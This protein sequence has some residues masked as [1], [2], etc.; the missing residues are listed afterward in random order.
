MLRKFQIIFLV[1]IGFTFLFSASEIK[2]GVL[3]P[4]TGRFD[5]AGQLMK[6]GI[7]TANHLKDSVL[8]RK[9]K[10]VFADT[11]STPEGT[12][13]AVE[14]LL[15]QGV[16]AII[17][18][19]ASSNTLVAAE[20]C[21]KNKITLVVP[22]ATN[23]TITEGKIYVSRI[24]FTDDLQGKALA[25]FVFRNLRSEK[26]VVFTD[27]T[28]LYS[29]GLSKYFIEQ[30]KKYSSTFLEINYDPIKTDFEKV[31]LKTLEYKPRT[32][33][34]TGYSKEIAIVYRLLKK[35]D[36]KGYIVSGDA[37]YPGQIRDINGEPAEGLIYTAIYHPEAKFT[38]T[39][40]TMLQTY[41]KLF[42]KEV[43][44]FAA[45]STSFDAYMILLDSIERAKSL[46]SI[47]IAKALRNVK[48]FQGATGV[49]TID[50]KTG[51]ALT[52]ILL[53]QI[54]KGEP[55]YLDRISLEM[56]K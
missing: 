37:T 2:I 52:S 31:V 49:I 7:L 5:Y 9:I 48:N 10:L 8:G 46:D 28:Q 22:M 18:E 42:S 38:K 16:V 17:G 21:E 53:V 41:K 34:I 26:V 44:G 11:E 12:N 54:R 27:S 56:L 20:L 4:L 40:Q 1:V 6:E 35:H 14:Y 43:E 33:V 47:A 3:A 23:P 24:C 25:E 36:F 13:R 39:A 32:V 45:V 30:F 29:V 51:N 19:Q 50:P 55:V 15:S